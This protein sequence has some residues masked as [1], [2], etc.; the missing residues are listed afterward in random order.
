MEINVVML[1]PSRCA[2]I[3]DQDLFIVKCILD[4]VKSKSI[5]QWI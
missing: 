4:S 1:F 3:F 2:S 5:F